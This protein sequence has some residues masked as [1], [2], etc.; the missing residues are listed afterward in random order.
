MEKKENDIKNDH[1]EN[2]NKMKKNCNNKN[3][4]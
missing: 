2:K 3:I 4:L 1:N